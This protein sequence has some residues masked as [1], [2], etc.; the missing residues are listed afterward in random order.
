MGT[1]KSPAFTFHTALLVAA[2]VPGLAVP[3]FETVFSELLAVAWG[4]LAVEGQE[5]VVTVGI[6]SSVVF[7][8][9][10]RRLI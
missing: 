8:W 1:A 10:V 4:V 7:A 2:L 9:R 5:S 6:P 3:G